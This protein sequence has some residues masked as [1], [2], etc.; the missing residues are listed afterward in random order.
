M[1]SLSVTR[2]RRREK[3]QRPR[4]RPPLTRSEIIAIA[5]TVAG[6]LFTFLPLL[7]LWSAIP[8][9]IPTHF[10]IYGQP[11]GYGSKAAL[12]IYP[13]VA[14]GVTL[15]FQFLCRYPWIFN[16]PTRI[17]A[18]NAARQYTRGR[19]LLRWVNA[20]VWLLGGI[21]WQALQV[22]R[23]AATDLSTVLSLSVFFAVAVILPIGAI[24]LVIIWMW[25]GQ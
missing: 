19:I 15:L 5:T 8:A 23:G 4:I 2:E 22:A 20:L 24:T 9:T 13:G 12:L 11:D 6:L 1:D 21:Q 7:V 18:E 25:R 10:N 3:D 17:T 16:Y 14:L